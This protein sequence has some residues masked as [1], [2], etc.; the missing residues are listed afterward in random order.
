MKELEAQLK[1]EL[2][3]LSPDELDIL[4]YKFVK[5]FKFGRNFYKQ[6]KVEQVL[7]LIEQVKS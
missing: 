2:E 1:R 3:S 6:R 7:K 5:W 4:C